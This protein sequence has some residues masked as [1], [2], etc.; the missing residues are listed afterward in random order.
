LPKGRERQPAGG[1]ALP[2]AAP[3][4]LRDLRDWLGLVE[5]L[6]ELKHVRGADWD[7][8]IGGIAELNNRKRGSCLLFDEVRGYP[9]GYRVVT[10]TLGT[11]ARLAAAL[12]LPADLSTADLVQSLRSRLPRWEAQA[13][14]FPP[15]FVE[16]GPV[17]QNV[18]RGEEVDLL[19][20]PA[21]RWHE[22]DGGR[23]VGTGCV[24]ITRDFDTEWINLGTY[25]MMVHG[26][27]TCGVAIAHGQH[28][29]QQ[30]DKFFKAGQPFPVVAA[31]GQDPLLYVLAG[32]EVPYGLGEYD[33]AGAIL[34]EPVEVVRGEVTGLP[35]P[36]TAEIVVE[37]WCH[38]GNVAPEGPFGEAFGYYSSDSIPAPV[39]EVERVYF[40]D[41]PI[42]YG[43]PP[44]R[45]PHD[46]SYFK[47]V[48]RSALLHDAMER[49]GVPGV[50]GCWAPEV[51]ASRM[52]L[53]VAIN[54]RYQ[55]HARQAGY[56]AAQCNVGIH[57]GR[58][59]IVVDDD[60][61][62]TNL[63]DVMWAVVSRSDPARDIEVMHRTRGS[64]ADPQQVTFEQKIPYNSRAIIDA[65]RPYE[66]LDVF[67]PVAEASPAFQR[68]LR[69]K[70]RDVLGD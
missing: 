2:H 57:L 62:S 56:I 55:G 44:G 65:C 3:A 23:Y 38:P 52:L 46:F 28:G 68:E 20:F 53:V 48:M 4:P 9:P 60:I 41:E 29:R 49:A 47:T 61:D 37:G 35:I 58:Y 5:R 39:M 66:Y 40:R 12:R 69:A 10:S 14:E 7:L 33:L 1:H 45:P 42:L 30:M 64:R 67:P 31:L 25:R 16:H 50:A 36:A 34:G 17:L 11:T 24:V 21:P 54:Q 6:G 70:W 32:L 18:R 63:E 43:A 22:L 13:R 15:R 8:E 59:V 19:Q 26:P 51:G 27:R